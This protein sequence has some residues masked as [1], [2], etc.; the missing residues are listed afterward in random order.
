MRVAAPSPQRASLAPMGVFTLLA[1]ACLTI[2]VGC[3]IVPALPSIAPALGVPHASSWL[4]TLPSLG[5]VLFAPIVGRSI[6]I[7]GARR[8]LCIG[9]VLYGLLGIGA[10]FVQGIVAVFADRIF[11]GGATAIVM[12]A[13][14]GLISSFYSGAARMN[15]IAR[16]GMAIELGGVVFLFVG[17]LLAKLGWAWPFALYAMAF[18]FLAMVL[19]FVP[20]PPRHEITDTEKPSVAHVKGLRGVYAAALL[21]MTV[22]FAAVI[23]LPFHLVRFPAHHFSES[24]VGFFL[25]FVSLIAVGAASIMPKLVRWLGELRA[26]VV[27][28]CA[29]ALAH[30]CFTLA[31]S[32]PVLMLGALGLG[33]G[34]GF[35][36]PLVNHMTV[37]RSSPLLRGQALSYL[38]TAIFLGQ[39]LSSFME[40]V[41]GGGRVV[42]AVAAIAAL[43]V[44]VACGFPLKK[45]YCRR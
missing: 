2:M 19:V 16:Q 14:T 30:I 17:G 20:M 43:G 7:I 4:I 29:Y 32:L 28:F 12:S 40:F 3:V 38:A 1:V 23:V 31:V 5:V 36:V 9:L 45:I 39:F 41:P 18:V 10:L 22:F 21:S 27:A 37:E 42:F 8:A 35:S 33:C 11:L 34:F 25:A 6:D 13:G 15:M 44:A 26:L 24:E